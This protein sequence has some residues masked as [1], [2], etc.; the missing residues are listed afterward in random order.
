MSAFS[1]QSS[2]FVGAKVSAKS[3]ARNQVKSRASLRVNA[4]ADGPVIIG[5]AADSGCGK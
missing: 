2:A 1:L 3:S 5:L 4:K